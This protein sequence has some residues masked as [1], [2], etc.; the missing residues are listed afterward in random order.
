[1]IDGG[2]I[3]NMIDGGYIVNMIDG[4]YMIDGIVNMIDD[5]LSI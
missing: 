1:M 2:Y 3:V 5:I 4:G